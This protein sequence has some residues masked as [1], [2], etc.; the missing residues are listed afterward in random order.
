MRTES[1]KPQKYNL[2]YNLKSTFTFIVSHASYN[3]V[4]YI[5][6]IIS[7]LHKLRLIKVN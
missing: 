4:R 2:S 1:I 3:T 7:I 5:Q 6:G